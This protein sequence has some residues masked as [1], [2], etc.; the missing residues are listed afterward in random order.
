M[1]ELMAAVVGAVCFFGGYAYGR[2]VERKRDEW[3]V[4]VDGRWS[5]R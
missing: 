3:K 4:E 1:P 2:H 5:S